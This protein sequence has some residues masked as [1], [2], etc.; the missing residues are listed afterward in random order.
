MGSIFVE[1]YRE[2][3]LKPSEIRSA[4]FIFSFEKLSY[5]GY[6]LFIVKN[7]D[8][9]KLEKICSDNEIDIDEHSIFLMDENKFVLFK[10]LV[11][12]L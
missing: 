11:S 4:N 10:I 1:R 9:E 7:R 2:E 3:K 6:Q 5:G 12:S 8:P